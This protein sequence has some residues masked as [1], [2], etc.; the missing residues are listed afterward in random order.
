MRQECKEQPKCFLCVEETD[1]NHVSGS[2]KCHAYKRA[3]YA[4]RAHPKLGE[5]QT[6]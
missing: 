2:Y 4:A 1:D 5:L 3:L 6:Q